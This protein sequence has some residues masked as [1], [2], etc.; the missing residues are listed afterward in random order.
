VLIGSAL[1][2]LGA[3]AFASALLQLAYGK[4]GSSP[5]AAASR[6]S[7]SPPWRW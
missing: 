7:A 6:F 4:R 5:A 3:C 1:P 2:Y